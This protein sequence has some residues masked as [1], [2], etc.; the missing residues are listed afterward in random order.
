L[1]LAML[2]ASTPAASW[3]SGDSVWEIIT[4]SQVVAVVG[5][6]GVAAFVVHLA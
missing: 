1:L 3:I 6:V 2:P 5:L 4:A